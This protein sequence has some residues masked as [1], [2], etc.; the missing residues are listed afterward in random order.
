MTGTDSEFGS[1]EEQFGA[2]LRREREL[3]DV[4]VEEIARSTKIGAETIRDLEAGRWDRFSAPLYLRGAVRNHA[5]SIGLDPDDVLLRLDSEVQLH[6]ADRE[7]SLLPTDHPLYFAEPNTGRSNLWWRALVWALSALVIGLTILIL[8]DRHIERP[9]EERS[10]APTAVTEPSAAT[11]PPAPAAATDVTAAAVPEPPPPPPE[12][13]TLEI[14]ALEESWIAFS[15]DG[16]A[17]RDLIL[18]PGRRYA[19][20]ATRAIRFRTGNAGGVLLR[21]DGGEGFSLGAT[22]AVRSRTFRFEPDR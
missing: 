2:F 17:E 7:R 13:H 19:V 6:D 4:S 9:V 5:R 10:S 15:A 22:G 20:E 3:R 14:R 21:V 11:S 8:R 1:S 16:D 18:L 12:A